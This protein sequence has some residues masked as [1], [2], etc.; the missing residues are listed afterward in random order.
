MLCSIGRHND[1]D[2][3]AMGIPSE[4]H[5]SVDTNAMVKHNFKPR[6]KYGA[7]RSSFN[8]ISFHSKKECLYYQKLLKLQEAGELLFFIRQPK[9]DLPGNTHY[10]ADFMEFYADDTVKVTDVK[11]MLT[12]EFIRAKKQVEALYP[13]EINV[14][15]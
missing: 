2:G 9:F 7:S 13:I 15:K 4:I 14:V 1:A 8:G 11:G 10:S 5:Q 3:D 12:T 6:S